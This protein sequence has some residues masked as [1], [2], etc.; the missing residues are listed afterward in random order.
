MS[1]LRYIIFCKSNEYLNLFL[2]KDK[3]INLSENLQPPGRGDIG[4][5]PKNMYHELKKP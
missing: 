2:G 3:F 1:H 5:N 4:P